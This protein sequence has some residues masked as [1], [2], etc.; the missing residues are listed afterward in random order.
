MESKECLF[1]LTGF[2]KF[3]TVV[4]NPT[5]QLMQ[6][7]DSDFKGQLKANVTISK[8][9]VVDVSARA[10]REQ[11]DKM[12][13]EALSKAAERKVIFVSFFP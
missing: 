2:D 12:K 4:V 5:A 7:I 1:F 8:T 11:I 6:A 3:G 13:L 10:S 9:K